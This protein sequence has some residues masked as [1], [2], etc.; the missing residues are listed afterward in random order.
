MAKKNQ[1]IQV[2]DE[3]NGWMTPRKAAEM[4]GLDSHQCPLSFTQG[5]LMRSRFQVL[6]S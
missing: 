5:N 4:L 2:V 3:L 1:T 6:F